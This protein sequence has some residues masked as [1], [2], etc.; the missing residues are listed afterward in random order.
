MFGVAHNAVTTVGEDYEPEVWS[1]PRSIPPAPAEYTAVI[2]DWCVQTVEEEHDLGTGVHAVYRS[3]SG[4][5]LNG[6]HSEDWP[7]ALHDALS[8]DELFF[9]LNE[10]LTSPKALDEL[11]E[12]LEQ[13][14]G[15]PVT[16]AE[17]LAW[18]TLSAAARRDG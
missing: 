16:E 11:P 14:I 3:L 9:R 4:Q 5:E 13:E 17:I 1:E 8:R 7:L 6:P 10:E 15:R 12:A 18:L 2:P